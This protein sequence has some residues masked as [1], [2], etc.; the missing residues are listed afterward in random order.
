MIKKL[1][2]RGLAVYGGVKAVEKVFDFYCD[3]K[4]EDI[5]FKIVK[6]KR[7]KKEEK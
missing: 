6:E 4:G 2:V 1:F 5:S 7:A 3:V